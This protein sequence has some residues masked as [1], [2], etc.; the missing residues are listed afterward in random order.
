MGNLFKSKREFIAAFK[1]KYEEL[2]GREFPEKADVAISYV[3][4]LRLLREKINVSW[5]DTGK[6]YAK[7]NERQIY[8][9]SMEF[10]IGRLLKYYLVNL[11]IQDIVETGLEEMGIDYE[12]VLEQEADPGT[13]NGGLGR[14]AACLLDSMAHMGM[15]GHGNGMRY[16]FGLFNQKIVNGYQMELPDNWLKNGY[17]WERCKREKAVIVKFN[18]NIVY[19]EENGSPKFT[20]ENYEPVLAVPYD[21]PMIGMKDTLNINNLR[22]WSA[23]PV[24]E[25][26]DMTSF[27][28]G[29]FAK[30]MQYQSEVE[31]ISYI[32][33]P[34]DRYP[35]GRELRLK[36]EYLIVS[37]GIQ[38]I[39][40]YQKKNG[41]RIQN[42]SRKVGLHINDTHPALCVPELM[43]ILL[44][45]ENLSWDQAWTI[46]TNTIS[47][48]N[49]TILPEALEKWPVGLVSSLLPRVYQ[50]IEEIDRRYI[51]E[52]NLKFDGNAKGL[53]DKTAVVRDGYVHMACLAIIGSYSVNGVAKLHSKILKENIFPEFNQI[54]PGKFTNITNGVSHRRFLFSANPTLSDL[55]TSKIGEEWREKAADLISLKKF[56]N[57]IEFLEQINQT[58]LENKKALAKYIE[59]SNGIIVNPDSIFDIQVKR[60]HAYKRQL[61]SALKIMDLYNRIKDNPNLDVPACTFIFAGKSAP[62]YFYAKATIKLINMLAEKINN[63]TE[64]NDKI[65]VIFLENFNVTLGE[66]IYPAAEISEQISTA[67]QEASGTG[68]MKFMFN[69]AVTLGTL[70]GAN[71]EILKAVG[72]ENIRIFGIT[73]EEV[74]EMQK[75]CDYLSKAECETNPRLKKVLNQLIDG[76]YGSDTGELQM[77]YD[78][79]VNNNDTFFVL[80]DFQSYMDAFEELCQVYKDRLR[81]A[82]MGLNNIASAGYFTS[83]RSIRDYANDIWMVRHM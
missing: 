29:N 61:L 14:L 31:A 44:D 37:A 22:L 19:S 2:E 80:N 15:A 39:I 72:S 57:E 41:L 71:V 48:T 40:R 43:R 67:S 24:E 68:N 6:K 25:E 30:A 73:A 5:I 78:S 82:K 16:R 83:D 79:L 54:Y 74:M 3:T 33:Y 49:H 47:Y 56:E 23:E 55:I 66:I 27:N 4:L 52:I 12:E 17:P 36:Q 46:T 38:S 60:I 21:I 77:I 9:F 8:Y 13:G 11:D 51:E 18:G 70:D 63:D 53:L 45:E 50:I 58:K 75:S 35:S 62:G 7:Y 1:E 28:T 26:M 69:G 65:K 59:K 34:D 32:L 20:L 10:L 42:L 64:I 81:W 76:S